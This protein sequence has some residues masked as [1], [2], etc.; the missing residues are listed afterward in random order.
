MTDEHA[1]ALGPDAQLPRGLPRHVAILG[2]ISLL[3]A[4][5]SA[6]VYGLLP[7]F[8]VRELGATMTTVG[9]IEGAAEGMMSLA[10]IGSGLASD[11]MGRRKPLVLFGYAVS[12]V[13]KVM[14]PLAGAVSVVLAARIID[15][16]GKGLRD[17]PRDA[18]MTDVTPAKIR[19]S[20][21]GLR[22]T[23][24][25]TGYVIGPSAAMAIMAASSDNFRLV[26]WIAVIPAVLAIVVLLFGIKE[27]IP[28]KIPPRPLRLRRA[29]L[30]LFGV[31]FWWAI[32]I[33]S[34]LSLARFSPA[35]LVL[36]A[37][38]IGID[39]ALVP[40]ML[41]LMHLVYAAA[42]YPFGV[43]A[44]HIDRRLQLVMGAAVL[45][46]ADLIL[47]N[48]TVGWMAA[49]GAGTWGLQMAVTQG[50]LAASVSDAAPVTLRG[51]AFG[52]YDMAI[53]AA[54]FMAS[55]AGGALWMVGG[56]SWAFG[57][58]GAIAVATIVLL[59]FNRAAHAFG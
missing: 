37:H 48:A 43:L 25:T 21:F 17:A 52:I 34:L 9:F 23:F 55:S 46:G 33:A 41:I 39:V 36:K 4:M 10:R 12:A 26:F 56:S 15:R 31:P 51:T 14:F 45:V 57:F 32:A 19:G 1:E 28:R 47:A 22:L 50:L 16:I 27:S 11:W 2:V 38:S 44:D 49:I 8:L 53:G 5:S 59:L 20:S 54:A 18:F 24:Y 13:N 6:M 3:T 30:A 29:D 7:V 42:A 58:S 35:F 40:I